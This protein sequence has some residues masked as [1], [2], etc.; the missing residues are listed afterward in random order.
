MLNAEKYRN[1]ILEILN[2]HNDFAITKADKRIRA[3]AGTNCSECLLNV[4][5][6]SCTGAMIKWL[7]SDECK[8]SIKLSRLEYE[9]LK[10]ILNHTEYKYIARD[11]LGSIFIYENKPEKHVDTWRVLVN[12]GGYTYL[13]I[14]DGLFKFIKWL[15]LESTSIKN[16]LDNCE[17][18]DDD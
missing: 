17:V 15:D 10:Y 3:C 9:I 1:Q 12:G 16:V 13:T 7:L 2:T 18:V 14:L 8:E 11:R 4:K 5:G 6:I